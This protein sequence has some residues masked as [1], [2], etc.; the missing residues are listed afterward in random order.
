MKKA[1]KTLLSDSIFTVLASY[2]MLKV[3]ELKTV[4][5][6]LAVFTV[7][8]ILLIAA[9]AIVRPLLSTLQYTV[10]LFVL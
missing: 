7:C 4:V 9:T 5:I 8:C 10:E 3:L 1:Y 2:M 6:A